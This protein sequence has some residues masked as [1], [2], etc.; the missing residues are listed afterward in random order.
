MRGGEER[1]RERGAFAGA[2][3]DVRRVARAA[4]ALGHRGGAGCSWLR[5]RRRRGRAT[6]ASCSAAARGRLLWVAGVA[7]RPMPV[8][9]ARGD[10]D[11]KLSHT[12]TWRPR[13]PPAAPASYSAPRSGRQRLGIRA[14]AASRGRTGPPGLAA[15]RSCGARSLLL[16]PPEASQP[17]AGAAGQRLQTA[18]QE[19]KSPRA[20]NVGHNA[21]PKA[22]GVGGL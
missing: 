12:Q 21:C 2:P 13:L 10:L 18:P 1:E 14:I 7:P 8:R 9:R 15:L 3:R 20:K 11:V 17:K 19:P 6:A 5:R 16:S 22:G 4:C